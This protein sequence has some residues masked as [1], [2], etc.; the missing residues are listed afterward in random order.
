MVQRI[1]QRGAESTLPTFG[2]IAWMLR[3]LDTNKR[4][5]H[6]KRQAHLSRKPLARKTA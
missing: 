3:F 2:P 6:R 1:P 5:L 4:L